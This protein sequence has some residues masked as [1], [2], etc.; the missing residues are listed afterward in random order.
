MVSKMTTRAKQPI[1]YNGFLANILTKYV[2]FKKSIG[3]DYNAEAK[4]FMRLD[5]FFLFHLLLLCFS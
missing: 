4:H 1:F 5:T 3:C 2:T